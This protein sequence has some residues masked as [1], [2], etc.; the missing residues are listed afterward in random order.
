MHAAW[1]FSVAAGPKGLADSSPPRPMTGGSWLSALNSAAPGFLSRSGTREVRSSVSRGAVLQFVGTLCCEVWLQFLTKPLAFLTIPVVAGLV[2]YGTNWVGVKMI[3]YPINYWGVQIYRGEGQPWGLFGWQG[4]VPTKVQKM[5]QRLV[6]IVTKKLLSMPEAF[7]R[8]DAEELAKKL[9]PAVMASITKRA[10]LGDAWSVALR[11]FLLTTLTEVVEELQVRIDEVLDL[12]YLVNSAFLKDKVLLGE[13]F[14]KAGRKELE[15]LVNSG[16][17][18]GMVLGLFQMALWIGIPNGWMLP[19]GGALVGYITN[20]VA[21]K[22][23]FDPVEPTPIG[24][25]VFQGLFEKRQKEVSLEFAE[26]LAARVLTSQRLLDEIANGRMKTRFE[27]MVR[28]KVPQVVPEAVVQAAVQGLRGLVAQPASHPV[29]RYVDE[30]LELQDTL[31]TRLRALSAAEFE[32]L[33]HPVFQEDEAILIV[34]GGVL[35]FAAGAAQQAGGWGG[36]PAAGAVSTALAKVRSVPPA[37]T[38]SSAFASV[39]WLALTVAAATSA[40][41]LV[42]RLFRFFRARQQ[43]NA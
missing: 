16:L 14:Q 36:P 15:F 38:S 20:W 42:R 24:P 27:D 19:V 3:F 32:N 9:E 43:V 25:F 29:H 12:Q 21:I 23:I 40:S 39:W 11:P 37:A 6:D 5:S 26:F 2:G 22:L 13:L 8:L 4:I 34:A 1:C 35:G 7:G 30:K 18:F 17:G 28:T 33:L 10:P 31:N 41:L